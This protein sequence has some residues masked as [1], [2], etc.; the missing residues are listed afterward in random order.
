M[1]FAEVSSMARRTHSPGNIKEALEKARRV[2]R[3]VRGAWLRRKGVI[4][5]GVGFKLVGHKSTKI[6]AIHVYVHAKLDPDRLRWNQVF[7]KM[8]GD[9]PVDIVPIAGRLTQLSTPLRSG[10]RVV[11]GDPGEKNWGTAGLVAQRTGDQSTYLLTCAHVAPVGQPMFLSVNNPPPW[12]NLAVSIGSVPKDTDTDVF[13]VSNLVLD[14]A[15]IRL[16]QSFTASPDNGDSE[17]PNG[18]HPEVN[19]TVFRKDET[20]N[21]IKGTVIAPGVPIK[22]PDGSIWTDAIRIEGGSGPFSDWGDSGAVVYRKVGANRVFTGLIFAIFTD[23]NGQNNYG[24]AACHFADVNDQL[25]LI[26]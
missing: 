10:L 12:N 16:D 7:P 24:S 26:L 17:D 2:M 9:V 1:F 11:P 22:L 5:V 14:C 23:D 25:G 13:S 8:R 4:D 21:E 3:E 6:V 19:D 20:G 15:L 18:D